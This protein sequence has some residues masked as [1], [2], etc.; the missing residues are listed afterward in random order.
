MS[1]IEMEMRLFTAIARF[2][3][4]DESITSVDELIVLALPGGLLCVDVNI[5]AGCGKHP[6]LQPAL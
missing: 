5:S 4:I 2:V 6:D 1:Y 3:Q